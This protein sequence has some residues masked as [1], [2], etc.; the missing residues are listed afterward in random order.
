MRERHV[1]RSGRGPLVR[2]A[3]V[4]WRPC[5]P[6]STFARSRRSQRVTLGVAVVLTVAAGVATAVRAGAITRFV[7]AGLAL[8]AVA[9]LVGQAI[10]QVGE[11]LGPSATGLLQSTLG[12]LPSCSS[13]CSP[14]TRA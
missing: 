8:A 2:R 4:D 3:T 13:P 1:T 11:R 6:L 5:L 12:N 14:S 7:L 9:A 10:E